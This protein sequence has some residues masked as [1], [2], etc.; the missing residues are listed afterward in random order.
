M[1]VPRRGRSNNQARSRTQAMT[2]RLGRVDR[3]FGFVVESLASC[4]CTQR[5]QRHSRPSATRPP[6]KLTE[7][8]SPRPQIRIGQRP[9]PSRVEHLIAISSKASRHRQW[10]RQTHLK[11]SSERVCPVMRIRSE[12]LR[13]PIRIGEKRV[14]STSSLSGLETRPSP[15]DEPYRRVKSYSVFQRHSKGVRAHNLGV[16]LDYSLALFQYFRQL[17]NETMVI[18]LCLH[19]ERKRCSASEWLWSN[20]ICT[21]HPTRFYLN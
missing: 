13:S 16:H 20:I 8:G 11:E 15:N 14:H 6:P 21:D 17:V 18:F 12:E 3:A 7:C 1:D 9:R 19:R 4:G 10:E 2:F 5:S